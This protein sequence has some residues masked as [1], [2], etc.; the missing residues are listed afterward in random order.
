MSELDFLGV[1][2]GMLLV[3]TLVLLILQ[4]NKEKRN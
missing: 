2:I 3:I 4:R 1:I